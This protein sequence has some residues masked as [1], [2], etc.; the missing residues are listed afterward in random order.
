HGLKVFFHRKAV[1]YMNRPIAFEEFCSRCERQ[2]TSQY[3]FSRLHSGDPAV[4]QYC[5]VAG[6]RQIWRE[7]QMTLKSGET[8]IRRLEQ[9]V[10]LTS[11]EERSGQVRELHELYRRFFATRKAKSFIG[12]G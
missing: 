4:D 1:Q 3:I 12:A 11:L 5:Q 10:S 7:A 6:N 9:L 2:G 8:Q